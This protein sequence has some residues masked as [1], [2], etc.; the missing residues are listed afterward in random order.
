MACGVPLVLPPLLSQACDS[1]TPRILIRHPGYREYRGENILLELPAIDYSV[2]PSSQ[3]RTRGLHHGTA[4]I[5]CGI[6]ANNAFDD[7]YFSYDPHGKERVRT[8]RDSILKPGDYWLQLT[9]REPPPGIPNNG[10]GTE[11]RAA[12]SGADGPATCSPSPTPISTPKDDE[13]YKYPI[14]PSFRDWQ[15]PH[16]KLPDEWRRP[17]RPPPQPA[18]TKT[19]EVADSCFLTNLRIGLEKCHIIPSAQ[20]AWFNQ[21]EMGRYCRISTGITIN[22]QANMLSLMAN[23]QVAFDN[24]LFVIIPKPSA[25]SLSSDFPSS[26][27]IA[28]PPTLLPPKPT[29]ESRPY[30]FAAHILSTT[31]EACDFANLY[32]N[33]SI[34]TKYINAVS[35]EFLFTRFAWALFSY[36]RKFLRESTVSRHLVIMDKNKVH[37]GNKWMSSQQYKTFQATRGE[38]ASGSKRRRG[39]PSYQDGEPNDEDDAYEERWKRRSASRERECS[40]YDWDSS[41][42]GRSRYRDMSSESDTDTDGIFAELITLV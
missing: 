27:S 20:Q 28:E 15:F 41:D 11:S 17:H 29:A 4:I 3:V 30:A 23:I 8:P 5:A 31:P 37:P 39:G 2:E 38:S 18:L 40:D 36:L 1:T 6:I 13:Y 7:A 26:P 21:N 9:G 12:G 24:R 25:S 16:D 22:D 32:H 34:H 42:R 33:V 14:V 19:R 35:P 10:E